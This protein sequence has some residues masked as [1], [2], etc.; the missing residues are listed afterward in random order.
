MHG[1][2]DNVYEDVETVHKFSFAQNS[3]KSKGAPKSEYYVSITALVN[4]WRIMT[5][6]LSP[7]DPYADNGHVVRDSF[8]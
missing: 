4:E 8:L 5:D 2:F 7:S 6:A 3:F 1:T